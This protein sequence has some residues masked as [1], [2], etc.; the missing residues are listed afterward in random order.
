MI[1]LE[2][3][4]SLPSLDNFS[5]SNTFEKISKYMEL[6][7]KKNFAEGG[8]SEEWQKKK[9][10]SPS[11][12]YLSGELFNTIGG[13]FGEDFAEAGAMNLLPYSFIH[14]YGGYAGRGGKA[15]IPKREYVLFQEEDISYILNEFSNDLLS[16][17]NTKGEKIV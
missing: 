17:F 12:L 8:R 6:S 10:G 11:N 1:N 14:Q 2:I 9:N 3:E 13:N 15:Y 5:F 4:G 7:I 16:F